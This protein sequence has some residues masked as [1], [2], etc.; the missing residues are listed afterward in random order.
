MY[1]QFSDGRRHC[2]RN[3]SLEVAYDTIREL[4]SK[5]SLN[6][7][8]NMLGRQYSPFVVVAVAVDAPSFRFQPDSFHTI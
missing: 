6:E 5:L 7:T 1:T 2:R 4:K 3:P 8:C